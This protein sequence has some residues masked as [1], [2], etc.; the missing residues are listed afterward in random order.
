ML[1]P[2][3]PEVGLPGAGATGAGEAA[4][5]LVGMLEADRSEAVRGDPGAEG[6]G[7][8][9]GRS[10]EVDRREESRRHL[11]WGAALLAAVAAAGCYFYFLP[12][13]MF[14]DRWMLDLVGPSR[15]GTLTGVVALRYPQVIVAGS[16]IAAL[17][18]LPKDRVR[19]L[20]CLVGPPLA[21]ATCELV[22]KPLVGRHL[23]GGFSYPSG[24]TVGAAAL[25]TAAVLAVPGRWRPVAAAIGA[26][27]TLW[28][29]V[30]V[31]AL[32]WHFPTDA[33]AGVAYGAG[34]VLAMD[35][36]LWLCV[37]SLVD[38]TSPGADEASGGG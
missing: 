1:T 28:M 24:S 17:V 33:V 4:G 15:N 6:T 19:S 13:P 3:C 38:R 35:G 25:T 12:G 31:V 8:L 37:T 32:Q 11:V 16:V 27:Y 14:V 2:G 20:A 23:G 18:V 7:R 29:G 26:V 22:V 9:R 30:A 10:G 5:S 34:V 36:A 21:L